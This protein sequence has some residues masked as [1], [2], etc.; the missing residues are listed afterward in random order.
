MV[1]ESLPTCVS[2]TE[3]EAVSLSLNKNP[4]PNESGTS[5]LDLLEVLGEQ[6]LPSACGLK[7]RLAK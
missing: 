1:L 4:T 2:K 6:E 7:D 3:T 5:R